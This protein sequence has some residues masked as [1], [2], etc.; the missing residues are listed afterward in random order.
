MQATKFTVTIT[1]EVLSMDAITNLLLKSCDQ[2]KRE[3]PDG[4]LC[5]DDGDSIMWNT[6]ST[7][8]AF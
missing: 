2:I 4:Q 8:V 3:V 6:I 5:F 1:I 7:K